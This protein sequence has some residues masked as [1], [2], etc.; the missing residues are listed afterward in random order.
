M[1]TVKSVKSLQNKISKLKANA[2]QIAF[3]PTMGALHAGHLSLVEAATKDGL[4]PVVSIFINPSQFNNKVDFKKYPRMIDQDTIL[5]KNS[6]CKLLFLPSVSEVYPKNFDPRIE[7]DL[8]GLDEL[9]E[10]VFRPGHFEGM[11]QVVK[12]LLDIVDPD[13]LYMGQKDFQQHTLVGHMIRKL[14]LNC[15]LV[16]GPTLR[17]ED[18]LAMSSRNLRLTPDFRS[19]APIIYQSLL[20][21]KNNLKENNSSQ[22]KAHAAAMIQAKDLKLEYFEI[23]DGY[24]LS[25]VTD[26]KNHEYIVACVACWAGDIRLIDNIVIKGP[27]F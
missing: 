10:G 16:I 20:Y 12:R 27:S 8:E 7:L 22:I 25:L 21:T 14:H 1:I 13:F 11:L 26:P 2:H 24:N 5:L 19:K 15:K 3:I 23:V 18:G 17:E 6:G 9:L 4:V